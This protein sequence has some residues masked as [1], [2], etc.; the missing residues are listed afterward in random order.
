MVTGFLVKPLTYS[1]SKEDVYIYTDI[2]SHEIA[3]QTPAAIP[4]NRSWL[5]MSFGRKSADHPEVL[6]AMGF[7]RIAVHSPQAP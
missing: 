7:P 6:K 3:L 2:D 1:W 4:T 5:T